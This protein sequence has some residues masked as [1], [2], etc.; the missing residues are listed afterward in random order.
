MAV[1]IK[2]TQTQ[3]EDGLNSMRTSDPPSLREMKLSLRSILGPR[4]FLVSVSG[5]QKG[6]D[7][8]G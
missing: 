5:G 8:V 2:F 1:P 3:C 4:S 6:K 7:W